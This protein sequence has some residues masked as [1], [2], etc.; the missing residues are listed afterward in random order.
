MCQVIF[1]LIY[2]CNLSF[3]W[4]DTVSGDWSR[5]RLLECNASATWWG[6]LSALPTLSRACPLFYALYHWLSLLFVSWGSQSQLLSIFQVS[7]QKQPWRCWFLCYFL[8]F[9]PALFP[10]SYFLFCFAVLFN[11]SCLMM[12]SSWIFSFCQ[13]EHLGNTFLSTAFL[14][15]WILVF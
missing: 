10:S 12:I 14:Q 8:D 11:V 4:W 3:S 2:L 5:V 1:C 15:G 9:H 13:F 7:S 6:H